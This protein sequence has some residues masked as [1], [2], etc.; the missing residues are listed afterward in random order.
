MSSLFNERGRLTL[1]Q[2]RVHSAYLFFVAKCDRVHV[3]HNIE[4]APKILRKRKHGCQK[5]LGW[6]IVSKIFNKITSK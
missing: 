6:G 1:R 2:S 5:S 3:K 4:L